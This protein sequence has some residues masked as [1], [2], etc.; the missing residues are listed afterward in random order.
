M[1]NS[2]EPFFFDRDER[3]RAPEC[4]STQRRGGIARHRSAARSVAHKLVPSVRSG[5]SSSDGEMSQ[6]GVASSKCERAP[7]P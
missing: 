2:E 5:G 4:S 1:P 3:A 6:L 7:E